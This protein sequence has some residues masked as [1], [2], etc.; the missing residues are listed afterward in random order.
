MRGASAWTRRCLRQ[1][2]EV[3]LVAQAGSDGARRNGEVASGADG[4]VSQARRR[5]CCSI[6]TV[7]GCRRGQRW[8]EGRNIKQ[9]FHIRLDTEAD[10]QR[11]RAAWGCRD[12]AGTRR[13]GARGLAHVGVIR[14]L[15]EAKVHIGSIGGTSMG[16]VIASLAAM[17][18]DFKQMIE[19]NRDAWMRRKPHTEYG[20]PIISLVRSRRLDKMAQHIWGDACI[21]VLWLNFFCVS[22]N[23]SASE[24]QIHERGPCGSRSGKRLAARSVRPVLDKGSILVDGGIVN[25]LPGDI[26]RERSCRKVIVVDVG[27]DRE[28]TFKFP[29][30]PSPWKFLRSRILPFSKRI[31]V[32]NI[33][34]V[35]MRT[36]DVGSSQKTREV[37]KDADLCLRPPIDGYGVLE[38]E[39]LDEIADVG[40][41]YAK[42]KLAALRSD[43]SLED[44]FSS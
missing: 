13:R 4:A 30:I 25:N 21:E 31:E 3:V 43:K 10:F 15:L 26:M 20:P 35:L 6:P 9:H 36:T 18:R 11:L 44:L 40:Y 42:E 7:A 41:R 12:R 17:G 1:A 37:K 23:L 22:C 5:W 16:A 32:P 27:S 2:D 14:A 39:S 8:F 33:A 24:M 28:F 29:E 38:F 19:I 34:D